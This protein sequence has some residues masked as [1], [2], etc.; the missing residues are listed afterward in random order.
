MTA[1]ATVNDLVTL[2]GITLS[3]ADQ[4]RVEA[5][6]EMVSDE[7]RYYAHM[8]NKDLDCM[9]EKDAVLVSVAKEVTVSVTFR[10]LRQ[11]TEGEPMTQMSQS[12]L[13]YSVSGTF[14]VPGGGIGNA[15]MDRDLKRLGLKRPRI[16]TIELYG[17]N[18]R[19]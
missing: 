15:I 12:A 10:I 3:E 18:W 4:E 5:L 1:F 8:V 14:A 9:I 6:L 13:G 17:P 16:G 7:L 2:Y 19:A 11:S